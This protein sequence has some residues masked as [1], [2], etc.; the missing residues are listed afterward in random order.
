MARFSPQILP[1]Y[2]GPEDIVRDISSILEQNRLRKQQQRQ[3]ETEQAQR[4]EELRETQARRQA[5]ELEFQGRTMS[6]PTF[7]QE[8]L[9]EDVAEG[10]QTISEPSLREIGSADVER[11]RIEFAPRPG[12]L[13]GERPVVVDSRVFD[14]T[15]ARLLQEELAKREA[16]LATAREIE[17]AGRF[18][19]LLEEAGLAQPGA[20][21]ATALFPALVQTREVTERGLALQGRREALQLQLARMQIA[22][23]M[24]EAQRN[25]VI[26]L[27][28]ELMDL[29]RYFDNPELA[30]QDAAKQLNIPGAQVERRPETQTQQQ[31]PQGPARETDIQA[32]RAALQEE[33]RKRNLRRLADATP[34]QRAEIVAALRARGFDVR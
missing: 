21:R 11:A 29:P 5:T 25:A 31:R 19:Q 18:G 13:P 24:T 3:F 6:L 20:G 4:E 2:F 33:L 16:D 9:Q 23:R 7:L 8:A 32:A 30:L 17:R 28:A 1:R 10:R 26:R 12:A 34:A 14:P 15:R 22:A 27:A